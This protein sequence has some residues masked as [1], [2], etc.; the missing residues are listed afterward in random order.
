MHRGRDRQQPFFFGV[1]AET[2]DRAQPPRDRRSRSTT[3]FE[4]TA[5]TFDIRTACTEQRDPSFCAPRHILAQVQLVRV[6]PPYP[7]KNPTNANSS[8]DENSESRTATAVAART[9][10]ITT[11]PRRAA[12]LKSTVDQ[13]QRPALTARNITPERAIWRDAP[14]AGT[15]PLV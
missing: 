7:A 13:R 2:R 14:G 15:R 1:P 4:V 6:R 11:P 9:T 10:C 12:D 5:E 3:G 8:S